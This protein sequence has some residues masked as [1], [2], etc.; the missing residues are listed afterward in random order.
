[1]L[2][3]TIPDTRQFMSLLLKGTAF[4][5]FCFRQGEISAFTHITID[6]RR[7]KAYYDETQTEDWCS[8]AEIKP[9]VFQ[10][11]K[12]KKTPKSMKLILSRPNAEITG[13][14]N[15][16]AVFW[17]LLFR[18]NTLLCTLS[19]TSDIFSLDRSGQQQWENWV[20]TFCRDHG[21]AI[22]RAD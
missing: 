18:E 13:Y 22:Q 10:A 20:L 6:G 2:A 9:L 1:M 14:L 16:S 12:G 11:V 17:N 19:V 4:D 3:F 7:N 15:I 5:D 21:I 8:W